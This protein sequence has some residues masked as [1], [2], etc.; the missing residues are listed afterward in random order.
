M[1]LSELSLLYVSLLDPNM[2]VSE[3]KPNGA[4]SWSLSYSEELSVL[5]QSLPCI[6]EEMSRVLVGLPDKIRALN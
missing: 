1:D 6:S 2:P 5:R 4:T 3:V